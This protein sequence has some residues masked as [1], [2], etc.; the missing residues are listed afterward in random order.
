MQICTEDKGLTVWAEVK[1]YDDRQKI[2][3]LFSKCNLMVM[4][5]RL[6]DNLTKVVFYFSL[7]KYSSYAFRE[8][9]H[10]KVALG[11]F[12]RKLHNKNNISIKKNQKGLTYV[13]HL[14]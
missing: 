10:T 5:S 12:I 7:K 14:R 4:L 13:C 11:D 9:T 6:F 2:L 1:A 8:T 3:F